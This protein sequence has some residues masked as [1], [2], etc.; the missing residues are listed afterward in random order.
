[1][2]GAEGSCDADP[3][4]VAVSSELGGERSGDGAKCRRLRAPA[5]DESS[6]ELEVDPALVSRRAL[7]HGRSL[8]A[9]SSVSVSESSPTVGSGS[10]KR[11]R[12]RERR[13]GWE[14][15]EVGDGR[16]DGASEAE[17]VLLRGCTEAA[18]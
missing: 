13:C 16:R 5:D 12:L 15:H 8:S 1:M 7:F 14:E 10:W 18:E 2:R 17:Q 11:T 4:S 6:E 9:S 3:V